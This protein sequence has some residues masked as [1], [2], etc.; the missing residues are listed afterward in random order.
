MFSLA[1]LLIRGLV[2]LPIESSG[3]GLLSLFSRKKPHQSSQKLG[4]VGLGEVGFSKVRF[5][6]I[7]LGWVW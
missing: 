2:L 5:G 6:K 4:E 3:A 7:K 1:S